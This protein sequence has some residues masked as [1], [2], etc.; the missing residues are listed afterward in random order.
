MKTKYEQIRNIHDLAV[1]AHDAN[2]LKEIPSLLNDWGVKCR[3]DDGELLWTNLSLPSSI[4]ETI[5]IGLRYR[6]KNATLT[7]DIFELSNKA[8]N[9]VTAHYKGKYQK[10]R[11]EYKNTHK[12]QDADPHS[13]TSV[14]T[15]S[16]YLDEKNSS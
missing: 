7:E 16:I 13:F 14:N 9:Q 8:P 3:E 2:G 15:C 4:G 10:H 12:E 1:E 6:K 5:T 11:S